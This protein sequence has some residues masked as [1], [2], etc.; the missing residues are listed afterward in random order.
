M[1]VPRHSFFWGCLFRCLLLLETEHLLYVG[2]GP[3]LLEDCTLPGV[4]KHTGHRRVSA[5]SRS[6][7]KKFGAVS[8][9]LSTSSE[10]QSIARHGCTA[11]EVMESWKTFRD[12]CPSSF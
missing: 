11:A 7:A 3:R 9:I 5:E 12:T 8:V 1:T 6:Q 2:L 10:L 4:S